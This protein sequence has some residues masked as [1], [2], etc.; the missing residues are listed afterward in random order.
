MAVFADV[1][2]LLGTNQP[3]ARAEFASGG[4]GTLDVTFKW[5]HHL[6]GLGLS[7]VHI[8]CRLVALKPEMRDGRQKTTIFFWIGLVKS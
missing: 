8:Q 6:E 5:V 4:S 2:L 7:V 1:G 3:G